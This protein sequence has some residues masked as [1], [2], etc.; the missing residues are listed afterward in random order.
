MREFNARDRLLT[1]VNGL[2]KI[3]PQDLNI[4]TVGF[5][6]LGIFVLHFTAFGRGVKRPPVPPPNVQN[7]LGAVIVGTDSVLFRIVPSETAVLPG[8][9][10][11]FKLVGRNLVI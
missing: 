1:T 5:L 3:R 2:Q 7:T 9:G 8:A 11:L 6:Q 4:V 10:E